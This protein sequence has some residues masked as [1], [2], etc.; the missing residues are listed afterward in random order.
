[1]GFTVEDRH[2]IKCLRVS[3]GCEATRLCKMFPDR[4]WN[5]YEVKTSIKKTDMTGS[6][7]RQRGSGRPRSARRPA[8]INT[9][10]THSSQRKIARRKVILK[11]GEVVCGLSSWL[12]ARPS[13]SLMLAIESCTGTTFVP[14]PTVPVD[15]LSILNIPWK[16]CVN[17]NIFQGDID[18][19]ESGCFFL[20]TVYI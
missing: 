14:I 2:L 19:N 1:M 16:L 7:D 15:T 6:I 9:L 11:V 8:N 3:K 17:L 10:Q 12:S 20:N 13:T 18:E 4:Q 5:V